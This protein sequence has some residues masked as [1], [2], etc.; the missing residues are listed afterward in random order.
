MKTLSRAHCLGLLLL[1]LLALLQARSTHKNG[2]DIYSL[3]VDSKVSSRFAHTVVTSRVVNRADS[4]QEAI[5]NMELPKKAF[6]TNFSMIIDEVTY[7]GNIKEKEKA[8]EQYSAAVARGESAA[9]VKA[10]GRKTEQFQVSVNVAPEAKV[11][12][13]LVYEE[14]LKRQLGVYE[15]LLKIQPQQPVKHLQIDIHIF[16][17]QGISFLETENTF[18]TDDLKNSLTTSVNETKA[19]IKFKSVLEEGMSPQQ[20]E[21]VLDGH[22]IVHYDVNRSLS[23]GSIQIE[24]GYFVHHFAPMDLP[25]IPK[26][27]IFVIDKSGSMSGR[28]IQQTREA[29]IKIVGELNPKDQFNLIDFNSHVEKWKPSLVPASAENLEHAK[30]YAAG[31]RA[32][33][34]TN[35]NEAMLKAVKMLNDAN[36]EEMLHA[37]SVSIIILLTDGEPTSG[38]TNPVIIQKNVKEA[39]EGQYY[40]F[41]LG[42]GFDVNYN[43]LEKMALENGGLARRIYED[44]DA[45]LQLQDFYQEVAHPLVTSVTFEYP[46]NATEHVTKDNFHLLFRGAEMVVAG[47]LRKDGLNM[48]SAKVSGKQSKQNITFEIMTDVA[49]KELEFQTPKYIFHGFMER[50]WAYLTI[51]QLLEQMIS[52]SDT[53]VEDM[54]AR[55]LE[56]SLKYNFVTPLTS[57]V[58]TKPEGQEKPHV[59]NKAVEKGECDYGIPVN[60]PDKPSSSCLSVPRS[61]PLMIME[62]PSLLMYEFTCS[63]GLW[64]LFRPTKDMVQLGGP[65][66]R[67]ESK[68]K[69]PHFPGPFRYVSMGRAGTR[70]RGNSSV[71]KTHTVSSDHLEGRLRGPS[72]S[73][74]SLL[75]EATMVAPTEAYIKAPH[76]ILPLPGQSGDQICVDLKSSQGLLELISDPEKGLQVMGYYEEEKGHFSWIEVTF[77]D[78]QLVVRATPEHI[79]VTRGSRSTSYKWKKTLFAEMPSLKMTMDRD[80]LLLLRSTNSTIM[81]LKFWHGPGQG[82]KLLLQDPDYFSNQVGGILGQFYQNVVWGP[83]EEADDSKRTLSVQG[84]NLL[85]T[86]KQKLDY[87]KKSLGAEIS[88]WLVEL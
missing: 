66:H 60:P 34:G 41:C 88:C 12:F 54:K 70:H 86:R 28:K 21:T 30:S 46:G 84:Q 26:N 49:E 81:G 2:I 22:F 13:V 38:E 76:A 58:V 27:V 1:S 44:S 71:D 5:F 45:N 4:S 68:S 63:F 8:E 62:L 23:G 15:L 39:I 73:G 72:K 24:Q 51:Q 69:H 83:L 17:P 77:K 47:K 6:V 31:L 16:E 19:H 82:L 25:T 42:F 40:L 61:P 9:L 18:V 59:I 36:R 64:L 53:E 65:A 78:N 80:G 48:I 33:G 43:F 20:Q 79:V 75:L 87:Q 67:A 55:A 10:V 37:G 7:P 32:T 29:L 74:P 57:M 85:A 35:I 56:L 50:L 11:T 52:S 14:L 3:M